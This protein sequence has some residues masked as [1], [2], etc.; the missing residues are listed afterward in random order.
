MDCRRILR[1]PADSRRFLRILPDYKRI[2]DGFRW[3]LNDSFEDFLKDSGG[4]KIL[5]PILS[6]FSNIPVDT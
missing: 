2:L 1:I 5:L 6:D 3:I 4:F